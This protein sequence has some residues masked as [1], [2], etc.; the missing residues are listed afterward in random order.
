MEELVSIATYVNS[1]K[2]KHGETLH[3]CNATYVKQDDIIEFKMRYWDNDRL[4]Y[5]M[6][7][8]PSYNFMITDVDVLVNKNTIDSINEEVN[9]RVNS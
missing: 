5:Y 3:E 8:I 6:F 1:L 4:D 9:K 2:I 7:V